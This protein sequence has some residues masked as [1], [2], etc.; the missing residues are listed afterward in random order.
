MY[1]LLKNTDHFPHQQKITDILCIDRNAIIS[2][3]N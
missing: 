3:M 1:M 2:L